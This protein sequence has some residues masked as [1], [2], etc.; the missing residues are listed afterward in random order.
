MFTNEQYTCLVKKYIDMV[1]RIALNYLKNSAD[2]EDIC[3]NVFLKLLTERTV[4]QSDEHLR[5][6]IV[7][8]TVNECKKVLRSPWHRRE[9]L[10]NSISAM[11]NNSAVNRN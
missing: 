1:Y 5:N 2:A 6:W 3:Q 7:R 8:V 9:S 10:E 11:T 4:F